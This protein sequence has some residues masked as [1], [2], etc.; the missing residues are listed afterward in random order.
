VGA[1]HVSDLPPGFTLEPATD[2]V[3]PLPSGFQI[4]VSSQ[5]TSGEQKKFGLGDTWPARAAKAVY[6]AV[7]YPGDVAAGK[8]GVPSSSE[9]Q[10]LPGAEPAG[11][12]GED[13]AADL[14]TT[15]NPM[16]V[17][18]RAGAGMLAVPKTA[19]R[20]APSVQ[21]LKAAA[22][23]GF[24]APEVVGLTVKSPAI[25]S[26]ADTAGLALDKI[27]VSD[28]LAPKTFALLERLR[29][30]PDGSVITGQNLQTIRRA[31]GNAASS[32][33]AT[34]RL[35]AKTV[36]D[37]LD[38]FVPNLGKGDVVAGDAAAAAKTLETARGNYS[39]AMH[40]ETIDKK[41]VQAELRAAAANS[42]QNVSNTIRQRLADIL[43]K[44]ELQRGFAPEELAAME[45]IVRGSKTENALRFAG[46]A[47][48]GGGGLGTAVTG[49]LTAG[50]APAVGYGLK[51]ISNS[52][53]MRQIGKLSELVR[54]NAPLAKSLEK[55]GEKAEAFNN[56]RTVRTRSDAAL[57]A[58]NL[59]SNLKNVGIVVTT[60]DLFDHSNQSE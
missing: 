42:G 31:F 45:A 41:A 24:E 27:G 44:P 2:T 38:E 19:A 43:I 25:T 18:T 35:A 32:P 39:S 15:I 40:A 4:E 13:R 36:I 21:E 5:P 49:L 14:I 3:A 56:G 33:D 59:A 48:G 29:K 52:M 58:R 60:R 34:E 57:A 22:T 53:T 7:T 23:A 6:S 16:S 11:G 26:F 1:V 8:A 37:H 50:V 55:F 17:A 10:A 20:E 54:S 30:A 46:N 9:G 51:Q 12:P 28:V 47:L